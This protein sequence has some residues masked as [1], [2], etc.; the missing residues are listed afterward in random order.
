MPANRKPF[1]EQTKS[2]F[3]ALTCRLGACLAASVLG[4]I[5]A[6]CSSTAPAPQKPP[7]PQTKPI[8]ITPD[9]PG[10]STA[11][12]ARSV[13]E[14]VVP[15]WQQLEQI[16]AKEL[17]QWKREYVQKKKFANNCPGPVI[18]AYGMRLIQPS[19]FR[20]DYAALVRQRYGNGPEFL[21]IATADQGAAALSGILPGDRL[22][23]I[24]S[25]DARE[26]DAAKRVA[27]ESRRWRQPYTIWL[28]RDGKQLNKKLQPDKLCDL[29]L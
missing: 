29:K 23:R 21:V 24:A 15:E 10:Q 6:G 11:P 1:T 26:L 22:T 16:F 20:G 28:E 19:S 25:I 3:R 17:A 12:R 4:T 13:Q 2:G 5:V 18:Y 14:T 27:A 7:A 8:V 9:P